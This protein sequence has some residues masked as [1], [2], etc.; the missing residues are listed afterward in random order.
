MKKK[1]RYKFD[2]FR[3]N[4]YESV[5]YLKLILYVCTIVAQ[6]EALTVPREEMI[7]FFCLE[8]NSYPLLT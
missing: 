6:F 7:L 3:I 1:R 2:D 4:I 8:R 5:G